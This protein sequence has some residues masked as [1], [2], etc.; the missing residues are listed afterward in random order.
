M[1]QDLGKPPF[2]AKRV[3]IPKYGGGSL[4]ETETNLHSLKSDLDSESNLPPIVR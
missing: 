1:P 2:I 4:P 3:S